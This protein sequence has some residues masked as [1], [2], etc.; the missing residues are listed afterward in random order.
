[1]ILVEPFWAVFSGLIFFYVPLYMK[2]IGLTEVEMGIINTVNLLVAFIC[3]LFAGPIT[4]RV[5]RKKTTL[6]FDLISWSVPMLIWAVSQN[7]W[8]FL[9]AAVVN[10]FVRIVSVSWYC[11]LV[12]DTPENK[13]SKVFGIINVIGCASG[14]F[15]PV[16]GLLIFKYG[17]VPTMRVLYGLGFVGMTA[18]FLIRNAL[19]TETKPGRDLMEKHSGLTITESIKSSIKIIFRVYKSSSHILLTLVYIITNFVLS[20]SF[21]Q[22]LYLKDFLGFRE[23]I[24]SVTPGVN[25]IINILLYVFVL[26]RLNRLREEKALSFSLGIGVFGAL[27]FILIPRSSSLMMIATLAVIAIGNFFIQ[28]YRDSVFMNNLGEHE[29]ADVYSAVQTISTLICIPSGY[30]AG[31]TYSINPLLPFIIVLVLLTCAFACSAALL[32]KSVRTG[33]DIGLEQQL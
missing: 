32:K 12:E 13:R 21:F 4:N 15:T 9:A 23:N 24:I 2:E 14:I 17:T 10:A 26:P 16:S 18:M 8:Y 5:G 11:L 6:T 25:A 33:Q 1:M 27:L 19:I 3:H 22:I 31:L 29:K 28:T 20:L 30:I 7:F